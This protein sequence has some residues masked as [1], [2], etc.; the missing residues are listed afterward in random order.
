ML[1]IRRPRDGVNLSHVPEQQLNRHGISG[2]DLKPIFDAFGAGDVAKAL[3]LTT[4]ELGEKFSVAGTPEEVIERLER[5]II[6]TGVNHIIG[7]VVDPYLVKAFTGID[8]PNAIDT[9]AQLRLIRDRVM[10]ALAKEPIP[11]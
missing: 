11:A 3:E 1:A 6:S 7:A 2:A 9:H 8:V 10:P 5:D 4:P